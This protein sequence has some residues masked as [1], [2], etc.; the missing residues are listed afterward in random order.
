MKQTTFGSNA[1]FNYQIGT[2]LHNQISDYIPLRSKPP[3]H[4]TALKIE[5]LSFKSVFE[6]KLL[7]PYYS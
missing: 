4:K 7:L 1:I 3:S 6:V 2:R 5:K